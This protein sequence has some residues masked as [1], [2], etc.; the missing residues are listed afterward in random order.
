MFAHNIDRSQLRWILRQNFIFFSVFNIKT[1]QKDARTV[2]I[3][4]GSKKIWFLRLR[5]I[6]LDFKT[7]D[8]LWGH[9]KFLY[10]VI[11]SHYLHCSESNVFHECTEHIELDC[12]FVREKLQDGI[13]SLSFVP[14]K[15]QLADMLTKPLP[16]SL[17]GLF[18][19]IY[20]WAITLGLIIIF[21]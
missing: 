1:F 17:I 19:W 15:P 21:R 10:I 14:S 8:D 9:H 11:V 2:H 7:W 5:I 16:G 18:C 12:H 13:I 6:K 4:R 3:N 20:I